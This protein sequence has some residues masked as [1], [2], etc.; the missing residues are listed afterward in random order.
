[1]V[2]PVFWS[3]KSVYVINLPPMYSSPILSQFVMRRWL[4]SSSKH[5]IPGK[6]RPIGTIDE[7]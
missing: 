5:V 3:V 2:H 6:G 4:S 7:G 1:M